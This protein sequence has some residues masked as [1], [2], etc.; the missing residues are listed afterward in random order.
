MQK[1]Y[2]ELITAITRATQ[3]AAGSYSDELKSTKDTT[4]KT[5]KDT[6][7]I[8]KQANIQFKKVV[9]YKPLSS[10]KESKEIYIYC[11]GI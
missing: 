7:E 9:N 6:V 2:N 1:P 10:K 11:K 3:W 4:I 5:D 8:T